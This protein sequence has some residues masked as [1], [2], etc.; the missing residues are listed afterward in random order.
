MF[1]GGLMGLQIYTVHGLRCKHLP[2]RFKQ[3]DNLLDLVFCEGFV[4]GWRGFLGGFTFSIFLQLTERPGI[5]LFL[6]PFL[7]PALPCFRRLSRVPACIVWLNE[8]R[9]RGNEDY[10]RFGILYALTVTWTL[11]I[12][13]QIDTT[14]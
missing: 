9:G 13:G 10:L 11:E 6:R 14:G 1:F 2:D 7:K 5:K 8:R 3:A 4:L 12:H